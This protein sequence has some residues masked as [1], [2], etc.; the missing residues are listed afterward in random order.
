M[1]SNQQAHRKK[2]SF[3]IYGFVFIEI[4]SL[5]EDSNQTSWEEKRFC[6]EGIA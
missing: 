4:L 6:E 5:C 3:W 1:Q 2:H